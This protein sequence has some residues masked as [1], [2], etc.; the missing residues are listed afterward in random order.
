MKIQFEPFNKDAELFF[1]CPKPANQVIPKWYKDMPIHMDNDKEDGLS[2]D[3]NVTSNLTLKGCSPFLDAITSG[4][5]FELPFDL[6]FRRNDEGMINIR[7]ATDIDFISTHAPEQAPGIPKPFGGN[8]TLLKWIPGWRVITPPGYSSFFTHPVNRHEL[9]FRTFS[10][11]VDTDLYELGVQLPF[12]LLN[13]IEK[14]IFI[15]EQGTP[16]CQVIPFKR[17]DWDS[18]KVPFNE[19]GNKKNI[20][21]LKSKLIRSYKTQ[22][23]KKK[24][25]R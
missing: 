1:N 11:V 5:I 22:F 15:L 6:E 18:E 9:P 4:Y 7:W 24:N 19:D 10:G 3:T 23:W 16:I 17:D 21:K 25:Y 12:Q 20:F 13:T 8:E 2:K 14:D